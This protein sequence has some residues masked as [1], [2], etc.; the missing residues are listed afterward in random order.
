ML[1]FIRDPLIVLVRFSVFGS[2]GP[3]HPLPFPKD[4]EEAG[5][6]DFVEVV[7]INTLAQTYVRRAHR[8]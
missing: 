2:Q 4:A 5:G 1:K 8:L 3:L 6:R 7:L